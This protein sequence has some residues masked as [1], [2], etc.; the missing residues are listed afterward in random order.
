[1]GRTQAVSIR[2]RKKTAAPQGRSRSMESIIA[3]RLATLQKL[4]KRCPVDARRSALDG[5]SPCLKK[6]LF[7]YVMST[8]AGH[9]L[10]CTHDDYTDSSDGKFESCKSSQ[11]KAGSALSN[12]STTD[13]TALRCSGRRRV[14]TPLA[15]TAHSCRAPTSERLQ[16]C[17]VSSVPASSPSCG[18]KRKPTRRSSTKQMRG[19]N[20]VWA[21]GGALYYD[22]RCFFRNL[23]LSSRLTRSLDEAVQFHMVLACVRFRVHELEDSGEQPGKLEGSFEEHIPANVDSQTWMS[24]KRFSACLRQAVLETADVQSIGLNFQVYSDA[25]HWVGRNVTSP[26]MFDIEETLTVWRRAE[27]ARLRGWAGV[28]ELWLTWMQVDRQ[29]RWGIH[30]RSL[31]EAETFIVAAEEAYAVTRERRDAARVARLMRQRELVNIQVERAKRLDARK[32][33]HMAKRAA[34]T[35]FV[36]EVALPRVV[37]LLEQ[38]L[39]R[40]AACLKRQRR[41]VA[42]RACRQAESRQRAQQLREKQIQRRA[43]KIQE[44]ERRK[45]LRRSDLTMNE[46]RQGPPT[47]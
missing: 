10:C 9:I 28:R 44:Q 35:A 47:Y 38:I 33:K 19:I 5:M 27:L 15:L 34:R 6:A 25:R 17:D 7:D 22:T 8:R 40:R 26:R 30:T 32:A 4:L 16:L 45:W 20:E 42:S 18:Q 21:K 24:I 14:G 46:L 3:G 37:R 41:E 43:G 1:M 13:T 29:A 12:I 31:E 2:K 23:I 36:V 39:R 11:T